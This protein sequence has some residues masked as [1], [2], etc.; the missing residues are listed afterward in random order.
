MTD[1]TASG[2]D[3]WTVQRI[4]QWTTNYLRQQ[5]V[6]SPRLEAELLLAHAKNCQRILLYTEFETPLTNDERSRMRDYVKRRAARE[7]L[8]YITGHKEFYGREFSVGRG[9][10]VPRPETE[11]LIDVGLELLP[12]GMAATVGEV[13]F[14]SG[15]IAVTLAKQRPKLQILA[16]DTSESALE[17]A[18]ANVARH[19]VADRVELINGSGFEPFRE[20]ELRFDGIVSNPPYVRDDE[21][22]G[23]QAEVRD[24]EPV[25]ALTS[26]ADGLELTR[27]LISEAPELL[28]PHGWMVVELDP[29]QCETA[30][31]LFRAA[32]FE[33]TVIHKD[34]NGDPRIVQA[35]LAS[36]G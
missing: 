35:R 34:L 1:S 33:S 7:P 30:A 12:A 8:A 5:N 10:L 25:Q 19:G 29:A 3:E 17:F 16:S 20:R 31:A 14:G 26:G 18:T 2:E 6:E 4:L 27:Q 28:K 32:G 13:G 15:C 22:S 23:L 11:T 24:H 21:L 36:A 9:V